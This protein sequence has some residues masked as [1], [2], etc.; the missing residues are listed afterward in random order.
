VTNITD[1][2]MDLSWSGA[3]DNVGI[4]SYAVRYSDGATNNRM[5]SSTTSVTLSGLLEATEYSIEVQARDAALNISSDGPIAM[6]TTTG[7]GI[8]IP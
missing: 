3:T 7:T 2:S 6:A 5:S 1:T 4:T 8:G